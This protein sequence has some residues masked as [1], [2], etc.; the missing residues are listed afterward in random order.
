MEE[1]QVV[2]K[3]IEVLSSKL[4]IRSQE[5]NNYLPPHIRDEE[6]TLPTIY[7]KPAS[8][9]VKC[10]FRETMRDY[11]EK[12]RMELSSRDILLFT[13]HFGRVRGRE[14]IFRK[15]FVETFSIELGEVISKLPHFEDQMKGYAFPTPTSIAFILDRRREFQIDT[16]CRKPCEWI[17][18]AIKLELM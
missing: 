13:Y 9:E 17:K 12:K 5:V 14:Y 8:E 16:E 15:R 10:I 7:I 2:E 18:E 11:L 1:L 6:Q 4:Y 3:A